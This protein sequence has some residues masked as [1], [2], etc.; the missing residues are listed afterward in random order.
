MKSLIQKI[1]SPLSLVRD[2]LDKRKQ[3]SVVISVSGR[4]RTV[5]V[6]IDGDSYQHELIEKDGMYSLKL[7]VS[8]AGTSVTINYETFVNRPHSKPK[9]HHEPIGRR[10]DIR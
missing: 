8:K 5:E 9:R 2:F 4:G 1:P 10:P 7:D 3:Q 6:I